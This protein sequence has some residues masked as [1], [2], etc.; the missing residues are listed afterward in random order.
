MIELT[1]SFSLFK[2]PLFEAVLFRWTWL[3]Q[4]IDTLALESS[5]VR[6]T[7]PRMRWS[8]NLERNRHRTFT[9]IP[10]CCW[11]KFLLEQMLFEATSFIKVVLPFSFYMRVKH[12]QNL[13]LCQRR[14]SIVKLS[15]LVTELEWATISCH[16]KF[17]HLW[18]FRVKVI[19]QLLL[20]ISGIQV[21]G[22][23]HRILLF[24]QRY[25]TVK[26]TCLKILQ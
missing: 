15:E 11:L 25:L 20:L 10:R 14:F 26:H 19:S 9:N 8:L 13:N 4:E 2:N 21:R 16:T 24:K 22:N 17:H 1:W 12:S 18:Q 23:T 5:W 6:T 7:D 3:M